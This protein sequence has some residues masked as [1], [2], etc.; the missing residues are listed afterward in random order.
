MENQKPTITIGKKET[1]VDLLGLKPKKVTKLAVYCDNKNG[2]LSFLKEYP[3]I[4]KLFINGDFANV[5]G[6]SALKSL[7]WLIVCMRSDADFTNVKIP[8]L[9]ELSVYNKLNKG[10]P[11]LLTEGVEYLSLMEIRGL[12]D[13]SFIENAKG[14]RNL[15]LMSL[16]SVEGL[17][18]FGKMPCLEWLA[19]YEM[20]KLC[21]IESLTRST[22]KKMSF[23]LA[24]DK[25]SGTKLAETFLRME[26][27][28][29][30]DVCPDR[31]DR[32]RY[33]A[34]QKQFSKVGKLD[35][36]L[37]PLSDDD[38]QCYRSRT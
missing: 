14:L 28:E 6:I 19:I 29:G 10:I 38:W 12:S 5:D 27:L 23:I 11:E 34:V 32:R 9:T 16:P 20:H 4:R 24:A 37:E 7:N 30:V 2:D 13:L 21:D 35:I 25:I 1:T 22:I 17:P 36:L 31:S 3:N 33:N 15:N 18:D 8:G 26:K